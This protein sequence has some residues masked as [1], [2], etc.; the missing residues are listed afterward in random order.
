M[1]RVIRACRVAGSMLVY[2]LFVKKPTEAALEPDAG[3]D[4]V[5][6]LSLAR[7]ALLLARLALL[8]SL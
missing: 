2:T 5:L 6:S 8:P 4:L 3:L 1:L 7:L